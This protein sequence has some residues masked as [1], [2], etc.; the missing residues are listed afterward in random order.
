MDRAVGMRWAFVLSGRDLCTPSA[1]AEGLLALSPVLHLA[2]DGVWLEIGRAAKL[3]GD[4]RIVVERARRIAEALSR[5]R[6]ETPSEISIAVADQLGSARLLARAV[7]EPFTFT[8][9]GRD[10]EALAPLPLEILGASPRAVAYLDQLG[11]R[12]AGALSRL[13]PASLRR[14]LGSEGEALVRLA[15]AE[16]APTPERFSPPERPAVF[17]E[18]EPPLPLGEPLLFL[19]KG[20]LDELAIRLAGR[21]AAVSELRLTLTFEGGVE[22]LEELLLPRPLCTAPPLL[23]LLRERL[24]NPTLP[25]GSWEEEDIPPPRLT[26]VELKAVRTALAPRAQLSLL[27]RRELETEQLAELLARLVNTLGQEGVHGSELLPAYLPEE[28][29]SPRPFTPPEGG[30]VVEEEGREADGRAPRPALVLPDPLPLEGELFPG[31]ELRWEGGG[32]VIRD[33]WG[34][35]RLRGKWWSVPFDRDYFVVG[36]EGGARVW[37]YRKRSSPRLALQGIFD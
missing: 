25:E 21:G 14:R 1:L 7:G 23:A 16:A 31:A 18:L 8:E 26:E 2:D 28:S 11:V 19:V 9:P 13:A 27:H 20:L 35:E 10:A 5:A 22:V 15:R 17:R 29:W 12:T 30:E 36:L 24:L 33:I 34:P 32:G 37:I 4:E 6:G 3:F